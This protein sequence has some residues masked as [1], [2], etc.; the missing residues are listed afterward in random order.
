MNKSKSE[1]L[2]IQMK[3][4]VI[5][6]I[7]FILFFSCLSDISIAQEIDY[8]SVMTVKKVVKDTTDSGWSYAGAGLSRVSLDKED[9]RMS[10]SFIVN[11]GNRTF[12]QY[13]LQIESKFLTNDEI[14]SVHFGRGI[15]RVNRLGRVAA[16]IGPSIV[17]V[18]ERYQSTNSDMAY[19]AGVIATLH[20]NLTPFRVMGLGMDIIYSLNFNHHYIGFRYSLVYEGNK[21]TR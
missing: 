15:S 5:Y 14:I 3:I 4:N 9:L 7:Y 21:K 17:L 12:W 8:D 10:Y 18:N 2:S 13:G 20:A 16:A 11:R 1:Y 19:S 6:L